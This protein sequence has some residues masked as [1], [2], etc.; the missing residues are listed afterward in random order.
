MS[1]CTGEPDAPGGRDR[2]GGGR[3]PEG[4]RRPGFRWELGS[5]TN[6]VLGVA[7][8]ACAGWLFLLVVLLVAPPASGPRRGGGPGAGM[9]QGLDG[10]EPPAVVS[11]LDGKLDR[12][13]FGATLVGLAAR[14]WFQVHGP[15]GG[16][17]RAGA[18]GR[19]PA[20]HWPTAS[21]AERPASCRRSR[22]STPRRAPRADQAP[23]ERTPDRPAV[24]AAVR[25]AGTAPAAVAAAH[26]HYW[27]AWAAG[28]CLAGCVLAIGVGISRRRTAA[29]Q[30][31]LKRW[32]SAV[33]AAPGDGRLCG[34]A[35]ALGGARRAGGLRP[36]PARN[37]RAGQGHGWPG[38]GGRRGRRP[39]LAGAPVGAAALRRVRRPGDQAVDGHG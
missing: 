24:P 28:L 32:R 12:T 5:E 9:D 34:Y 2:G 10:D 11:L 30:A 26:Q 3:A 25:P 13:G 29:G 36:G 8:I 4:R 38:P 18:A 33:A 23:A 37:G 21:R 39:G 6:A 7:A 17:G 22:R 35:A 16:S 1:T 15:G 31:A 19:C 27:L 14:G 20:L